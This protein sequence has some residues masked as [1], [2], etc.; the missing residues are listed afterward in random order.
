MRSLTAL[1]LLLP[2]G[3]QAAAFE[4]PVPQAQT[5]AA[6]FWFAIA[7]IALLISLVAVQWLVSRR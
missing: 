1:L 6:E 7:S 2:S 4:Q 5:D 3:V